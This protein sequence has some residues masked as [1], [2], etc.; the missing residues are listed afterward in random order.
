[1]GIFIPYRHAA[2]LQPRDYPC[3]RVLLERSEPR[4]CELL[5]TIQSMAGQLR[6][7]GGEPPAP[8]FEQD[9]FPRLDAAAAYAI[10]HEFQPARIIEIGCGHSTRVIARAIRDGAIDCDHVCIDPAPR[11]RLDGLELRHI[12]SLLE[13]VGAEEIE[14]LVADD[15]LFIDSSHIAMPGSDVDYLINGILPR[16]QPGCLVHFHDIFLPDPY[17]GDWAWRGY[18]EQLLV[19]ALLQSGGYEILFAS[20]YQSSK[21]DLLVTAPILGELPLLPGAHE[22]SLWLRKTSLAIR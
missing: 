18:N 10:V 1:M 16:L 11:A 2:T 14:N 21:D 9:W 22:S 4:Q 19:A 20:H 3:L 5:R 17:P 12:P 8:R 7:F 15:I 13:E 6:A